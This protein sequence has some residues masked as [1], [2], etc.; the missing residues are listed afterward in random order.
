[1]TRYLIDTD[2]LIDY[3]NHIQPV[4]PF[5]IHLI[6]E[7]TVAISIISI[8]EIRVGWDDAQA[9]RYIPMLTTLFP[10]EP[11]TPEVAD[12]AGKLRHDYK[13][14]GTTLQLL[15]TLIAATAMC[16]DLC[17][18]TRNVKDF[19]MPKLKLYREFATR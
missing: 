3:V 7:T 9:A 2:I 19:P 5:V 11:I 17:L 16:Q 4:E 6:E 18:V 10:V 15:D 1:M 14:R 8:A 12:L 13:E